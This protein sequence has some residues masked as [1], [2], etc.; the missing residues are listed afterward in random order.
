MGIVCPIHTRWPPKQRFHFMFWRKN[1]L[2]F[3]INFAYDSA[4]FSISF[5]AWGCIQFRHTL[6]L[7]KYFQQRIVVFHSIFQKQVR[8]KGLEN[9]YSFD[10][11]QYSSSV[12]LITFGGISSISFWIDFF[13]QIEV[14]FADFGFVPCKEILRGRNWRGFQFC[15]FVRR[16]WTRFLKLTAL[17]L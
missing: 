12:F 2:F 11:S 17:F 1:L 5:S 14:L 9:A 4:W 6:R 3:V 8:L 16:I 10:S 15:F 13:L 7:R